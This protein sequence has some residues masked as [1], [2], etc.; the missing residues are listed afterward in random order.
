[1][2]DLAPLLDLC[3]RLDR[4]DVDRAQFL[5]GF[6]RELTRL[7][8]CTRAGL[9]LF[10]DAPEGRTLRCMGAHDAARDRMVPLSDMPST[11][12]GPYFE[13]LLREGC[14]VAH[15]ARTHP[16]TQGFV[17]DYLVPADVHSLLDVCFSVNGVV[18][19]TFR[20]EEVGHTKHWTQRQ[21]QLLRQIGSRISLS[22]THAANAPVDTAPGA[23]WEPSSPDRFVTLPAP[24][25][26]ELPS[27]PVR[28]KP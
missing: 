28:R 3:S 17:D 7:V 14:V 18:F 24:L 22:L 27:P 6:T 25:D 8:H 4:G 1:M 21:V 2:A 5:E 9:W 26:P 13:A 19:G 10:V 11:P 16:A 23:L 15:D 20:C 12:A